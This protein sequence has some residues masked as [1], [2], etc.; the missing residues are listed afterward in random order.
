MLTCRQLVKMLSE[1]FDSNL[2]ILSAPGIANILVFRNT[3]SKVMNVVKSDKDDIETSLEKIA[4]V[5]ITESLH[6]K[7]DQST[8]DTR[9]SLDDAL[10]CS[11]PTLLNLLSKI[12]SKL[13]LTLPAAMVGNMF[14]SIISKKPTTLQISLGLVV[15]EKA[16]I[17]LF[18]ELGIT[19][20]YD[21]I[22]RFK[23]SAVHA[24][25]KCNK[26]YGISQNNVG[27]V[28]ADNFDANI[29]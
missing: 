24:A 7:K 10:N 13:D 28:V 9:I 19:S 2:L 12:S 21:E 17:E 8:F 16:I 26:L 23:S 20:S 18:Y 5:I 27:Q 29:S 6:I 14:T 11:S 4:K 22:L 3:A 15:R 25:E 1:H